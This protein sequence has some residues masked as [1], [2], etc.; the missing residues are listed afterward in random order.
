MGRK[1]GTTQGKT[2]SKQSSKPHKGCLVCGCKVVRSRGQCQRCYM[3]SMRMI[4]S[5]EVSEKEL[6]GKGLML[7]PFAK[8]EVRRAIAQSKK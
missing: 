4:K 3:N 6:T 8:N 7:E 5:G 2:P 1:S